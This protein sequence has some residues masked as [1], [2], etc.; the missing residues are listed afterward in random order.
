MKKLFLATI[1]MSVF[2]INASQQP[3]TAITRFK[4]DTITSVQYELLNSMPKDI[5]LPLIIGN[6]TFYLEDLEK[7]SGSQRDLLYEIS[8]PSRCLRLYGVTNT[9]LREQ[10]IEKLQRIIPSVF[11]RNFKV[12]VIKETPAC[13]DALLCLGGVPTC[14][15]G[16]SGGVVELVACVDACSVPRFY[17]PCC[18]TP[19]PWVGLGLIL[20]GVCVA[21]TCG[22]TKV[23]QSFLCTDREW[24]SFRKDQDISHEILDLPNSG[25]SVS[26]E[27][28]SDSDS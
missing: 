17:V 3:V 1:L 5:R 16:I 24:R 18:S 15:L 22:L 11:K 19:L 7:F 12:F 20:S 28:S 6:K 27:S 26:L 9:V 10:D 13:S 25:K 23:M 2:C 4:R 8:H 14:G 21:G